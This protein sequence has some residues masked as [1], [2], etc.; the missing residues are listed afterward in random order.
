MGG[1]TQVTINFDTSHL[2]FPILIACVLG[3]LGLAIVI[4]DRA[5]LAQAG[6]HWR[7][8]WTEMDRFR[9]LGVLVLTV[10]YFLA[11]VPVGN[12]WPNTGLGFLIC[13]VPFVFLTGCLFSHDRSVATLLPIG[14]VSLIAPALVWWLFTEL[15]FLTLP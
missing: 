6:S 5:E 4:R 12:V 7:R 1:L 2:I 9:F 10:V 3:V 13:S 8:I 14:V 15:F 11:M